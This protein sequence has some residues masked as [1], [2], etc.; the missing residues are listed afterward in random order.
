MV[1]KVLSDPVQ[2]FFVVIIGIVVIGYTL[3]ELSHIFLPFVIAYFIFF[4]FSPLNKILTDKKI[5]LFLVIILD[6]AVIIFLIWGVSSFLV[7]SFIRFGAE[8]PDYFTKLNNIVRDAAKSLGIRD[9][10]FKYFSIQ[11]ILHT[12]DYKLVAEDIFLTSFNM[13]GNILFILFF[14][15]F[16]VTGHSGIYDSIKRRYVTKKV[17]PEIKAIL[18]RHDEDKEHQVPEEIIEEE[19]HDKENILS[20]TFKAITGQIQRYILAKVSVNLAAGLTTAAVLF[21]MDIDFPIIWGLFVFLFNFIPTIGSALALIL[22]VLM[23]LIQYQSIGF[24]LVTAGVV[25]ATQTIFFNII[26]PLI[27]GRRLNLNPLLILFSVLIWGYIW[28]VVGMLLS[29]P[30]TAIIKI[31]IAN[32]KSKNLIFIND[33]MSQD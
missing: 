7:D 15:V 23:S 12:I 31:I 30:L 8:L 29:V 6:L 32:S 4:A 14:Y 19:I 27:I 26:E 9:A 20:E 33:L 22:P 18:K 5:P 28:G 13:M 2:K 21:F 1:R 16:I 11:K 17:K 25:A 3:R 10:Y 24:A